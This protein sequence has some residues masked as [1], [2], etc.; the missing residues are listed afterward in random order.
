MKTMACDEWAH[1]VLMAA[2]KHTDDTALLRKTLLP[3]LLVRC[4]QC[5]PS[6]SQGFSASRV[7]HITSR[8][9]IAT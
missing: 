4:M 6:C 1:I 8:S 3:E 7:L 9:I 2:L 5:P